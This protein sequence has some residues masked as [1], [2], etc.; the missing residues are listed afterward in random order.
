ML[1]MQTICS[2]C[3]D[4]NQSSA[5]PETQQLKEKSREATIVLVIIVCIFLICNFWGFVI[6]VAE[7]VVGQETLIVEH[8]KFYA[9][10]RET[11][12]FLAIVNSSINFVIYCIFGKDFREQLC[13][14]YGCGLMGHVPPPPQAIATDK[15]EPWRNTSQRLSIVATMLNTMRGS[16]TTQR[17]AFKAYETRFDCLFELNH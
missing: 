14:V 13:V 10:S 7:R 1:D 17:R 12:N 11:I 9:F 3:R 2:N 6:A 5:S 8:T 16:S 15:F 4:W